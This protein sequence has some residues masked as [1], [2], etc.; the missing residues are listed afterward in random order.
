MGRTWTPQNG[1]C[2]N[3]PSFWLVDPWSAS[4]VKY[5]VYHSWYESF[6]KCSLWLSLLLFSQKRELG[7]H[8]AGCPVPFVPIHCVLSPEPPSPHLLLVARREQLHH[9]K[10]HLW[11]IHPRN[12]SM[13]QPQTSRGLSLPRLDSKLQNII[14]KRWL[15]VFIKEKLFFLPLSCWVGKWWDQ[16][17]RRQGVP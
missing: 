13:S 1:C 8:R 9:S 2:Y 7:I 16:E 15:Y 14:T 17:E 11:V 6:N 4:V 3:Q 5:F 10:Q 12:C